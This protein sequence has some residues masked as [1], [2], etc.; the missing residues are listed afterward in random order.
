[1]KT[2]FAN[3]SNSSGK[4]EQSSSILFLNVAAASSSS[5]LEHPLNDGYRR[6]CHYFGC[7]LIDRTSVLSSGAPLLA[8]SELPRP[9]GAGMIP[10]FSKLCADR[11]QEIWSRAVHENK[12][13]MV[14]WSGGLDS[15]TVLMSLIEIAQENNDLERL[16]V[17]YSHH[18]KTEHPSMFKKIKSLR[19]KTGLF[20]SS[21]SK[22]QDGLWLNKRASV[23]EMTKGFDGLVVTGE[24]GDQMFG[25]AMALAYDFDILKQPWPAVLERMIEMRLQDGEAARIAY[26]FVAPQI[27]AG[28]GDK[29]SAYKALWWLNISCKWNTVMLRMPVMD[30]ASTK[31]CLN[32]YEHFFATIPFQRWALSQDRETPPKSWRHYKMEMR[33]TLFTLDGDEDY[34]RTKVKIPSLCNVFPGSSGQKMIVTTDMKAHT[35]DVVRRNKEDD[36]GG[37][38]MSVSVWDDASY[39]THY[40][41]FSDGYSDST[42]GG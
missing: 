19:K 18:S 25:S 1:M 22:S 5:I 21:K 36:D 26:D 32:R 7:G 27:R 30:T 3:A 34:H 17:G 13:I 42:D 41:N 37:V 24:G 12:E 31:D 28:I 6:I 39:K 38:E 35:S 20:S 8:V 9:F 23:Q 2:I 16:F 15:S 11:A 40:E 14:L 33:E 29:A 4:T 10:D